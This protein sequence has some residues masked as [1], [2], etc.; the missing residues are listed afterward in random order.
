M[1]RQAAAALL[2]SLMMTA[3]APAQEAAWTPLFDGKTLEGWTH[4]GPGQFVVKEG[5]L[6]TEGGMGLL[7]YDMAKLDHGTIRVV[8]RTGTPRSNSGVYIRI[9]DKP[10]EPWYAVHNGFEVQIADGGAAAR[11]TGSIYTFAEA[12]AQPA[13]PQDW[14]TLEITLDGQKVATAI[15]GTPVATFDASTLDPKAE[16]KT[17]PGDPA[18]TPRVETGYIGLQ[19]HD[20]DSIV[21]FKEVSFRPA[22]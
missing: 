12:K 6:R 2:V 16:P 21:E 4:V 13:K 18:R 9:A 20:K 14:N 11:G 19:N 5:L 7:F 3:G 17:A 8:Y 15:N 1:I 22:K 10:T